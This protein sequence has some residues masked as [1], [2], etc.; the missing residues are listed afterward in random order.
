VCK[1]C[2][3]VSI[4]LLLLVPLVLPAQETAAGAE[5]APAPKPWKFYATLDSV[6]SENFSHP[7]D[8]TNLLRNFD[9][10]SDAFGLTGATV[11][12]QYAGDH[13]GFHFDAGYGETYRTI[14]STDSWRGPNQYVGQMYVS[15]KP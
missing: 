10:Q 2:L 13:F 15:Y 14:G 4:A 8:G 9:S 3:F 5:A 6:Y 12:G 1:P 7:A 11:G